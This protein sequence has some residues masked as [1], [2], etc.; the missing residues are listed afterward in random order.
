M[1]NFKILF[2]IFFT[3]VIL[4]TQAQ[5]KV[6]IVLSG[7]GAKG[8]SHIGFLKAL[9]EH[10]IKVD[11]I[12]GTSMGAIVGGLYAMG[13]SAKEIEQVALKEDWSHL[14]TNYIPM[15]DI[16]IEE[17]KEY[18]KYTGEFPIK[19]GKLQLPA[20]ILRGQ[21]LENRLT[22]LTLPAYNIS[23]FDSLPIPFRAIATD[24]VTG[25]PVILKTGSLGRAMRASMG[26]PTLFRPIYYEG[27]LLIDGG[28]VRNFPVEEVI[29]MGADL[30]VGNYVGTDLY[31]E[32]EL[33]SFDKVILQIGNFNDF[34]DVAKQKK[35][36]DFLIEPDMNG[37]STMSFESVDSLIEVGYQ[38][39]MEVLSSSLLIDTKVKKVN[40]LRVNGV[41]KLDSILFEGVEKIDV[42]LLKGKLRIYK[43]DSVTVEIV[44]EGTARIFGTRNFEK[45]TYRI[46]SKRGVNCL[47]VEVIERDNTFFKFGLNYNNEIGAALIVNTTFRNLLGKRSRA[48]VSANIAE[49]PRLLIDYFKYFGPKQNLGFRVSGSLDFIKIPLHH[50]D[51]I[52]SVDRY[53]F[54]GAQVGIQSSFS[55]TMAISTGLIGENVTIKPTD[56]YVDLFTRQN[57]TS[58]K[59][60]LNF[61]INTMERRV[62]PSKGLH[63]NGSYLFSFNTE[64]NSYDDNLAESQIGSKSLIPYSQLIVRSKWNLKASRKL[65][66][67]QELNFGLSFEDD[68]LYT[69]NMF[70][71]GLPN[72]Y[73][74]TFS[75]P[76]M[77]LYDQVRPNFVFATTGVQYEF[78]KDIFLLGRIGAIRFGETADFYDSGSGDLASYEL[79][80]MV[81]LGYRSIIGPIY[82]GYAKNTALDFGLFN[83][84]VG[85]NF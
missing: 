11:Y 5:Q 43:G 7:G 33:Q 68:I 35:K 3:Q 17:K 82:M 56:D 84:F 71:G 34:Y 53:A 78:L 77:R 57:F 25:K 37:F 66:F 40:N 4:Y 69:D 51:T 75:F 12:T 55:R 45:V 22:E 1:N 29:E 70:I 44:E 26:M 30:V 31:S 13:Y 14:M 63:F 52:V 64:S 41:M 24:I 46:E 81:G 23:D 72:T 83:I 42:R 38:K 21:K 16:S 60:F 48:L 73:K 80:G 85:H 59:G 28:L 32:E 47:I 27:N 65:S 15:S 2:F 79:G 6:G 39:A 54:T 20:S 36:C 76:G 18:E 49:N 61:E 74:N 62:F 58:I 19:N 9:D 10:N 67:L 50:N 8:L